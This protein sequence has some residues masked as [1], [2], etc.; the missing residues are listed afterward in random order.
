MTNLHIAIDSA[1]G[2]FAALMVMEALVKPIAT[3]TGKWLLHKLDHVFP[4]IPDWLSDHDPSE[5]KSDQGPLP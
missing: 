4:V 5:G 1:L 2:T 3:R